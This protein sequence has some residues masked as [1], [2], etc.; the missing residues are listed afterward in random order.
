MDLFATGASLQPGLPARNGDAASESERTDETAIFEAFLGLALSVPS[1]DA[2]IVPGLE[3]KTA[4]AE[5]SFAALETTGNP[6]TAPGKFLPV[7]P[8]EAQGSIAEQVAAMSSVKGMVFPQ[9]A[10]N[11]SV[12]S[13]GDAAPLARQV[14]ALAQATVPALPEPVP[15]ATEAARSIDAAQQASPVIA[16]LAS[17]QRDLPL[18]YATAT[19]AAPEKPGDPEAE[20]DL[21]VSNRTVAGTALLRPE[22]VRP[23]ASAPVVDPAAQPS[24]H[25]PAAPELAGG[26]DKTE[27]RDTAPR[28]ASQSLVDVPEGAPAMATSPEASPAV[29]IEPRAAQPV[30]PTGNASARQVE[31]GAQ[32][33]GDIVDRLA[34]AREAEAPDMVQ[35]SLATREFGTV[36]MQLRAVEGRLHVAMTSADPGFAPAVQAA[37]A[38]A[39]S[40][41]Q[42]LSD[43]PPQQQGQQ[44]GQQSSQASASSQGQAGP[45]NQTRQQQPERSASSN[46][47][48]APSDRIANEPGQPADP[49]GTADG[50]IYA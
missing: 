8:V 2:V 43:S 26:S 34:R 4:A 44:Q 16:V 13:E 23:A 3:G 39:G 33:F 12:D 30:Q 38:V 6:A 29:L 15:V 49:R 10:P 36:A 47:A 31:T 20:T 22:P 21:A 25:T 14:A 35:S 1:P 17:R 5:A 48:Q 32:Q 18:Q 45:D 42:A 27:A 28:A 7:L 11:L 50:A 37:S 41:Q 24:T 19:E 46:S 9:A 40:S